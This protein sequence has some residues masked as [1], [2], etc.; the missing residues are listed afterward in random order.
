MANNNMKIIGIMFLIMILPMVMAATD[1]NDVDD[2][3]KL[4]DSVDYKKPCFNNGTYCSVSS[5]CNFTIFKP[6]NTIL[7]DNQLG[8]NQGA[9]H[10]L[11]FTPEAVGIYQVDMTCTDGGLN[12]AETLYF[13]VTGSGFHNTIWFYVIILCISAGIMILGFKLLDPPI[14]ILGTFGL[15]FL[16]IYTLLNGIVGI[17][18]LITTWAIGIII[19]GLAAYISIKSSWELINS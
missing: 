6:D 5:T 4:S 2:I 3:F 10:N 12:G 7:I 18:D 17:R 9:Y 14:V 13:E 8:T 16:G 1:T 15:Y 11:T 19:L